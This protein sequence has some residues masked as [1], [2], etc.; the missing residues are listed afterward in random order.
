VA[1]PLD[2]KCYKSLDECLNIS[3]LR[4]LTSGPV[5]QPQEIP[6]RK[7]Q[8]VVHNVLIAF[9][10]VQ[11][12]LGKKKVESLKILLDT[13]SS[14]S[15]IKCHF[16]RK[17]RCKSDTASEWTTAAGL[18]KTDQKCK[19]NLALP[20]FSMT[21]EI[22]WEVHVG[23][24]ENIH[25]DMIIRWDLLEYLGIDIQFSKSCITW[26]TAEILM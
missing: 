19:I 12:S 5:R 23:T 1:N 6:Q 14:E 21:R 18:I 16:V 7:H 17:L 26:D 15:H 8:K 2:V 3:I 22:A 10:H 13:G 9:G 25:Y 24:L 4:R 11:T 20:E